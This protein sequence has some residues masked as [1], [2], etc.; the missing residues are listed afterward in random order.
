MHRV[1]T[2]KIVCLK[3]EENQPSGKLKGNS[4]FPTVAEE[5]RCYCAN[6]SC[7]DTT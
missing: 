3:Q 1:T 5:M 2:F 6:Q 7:L 4:S